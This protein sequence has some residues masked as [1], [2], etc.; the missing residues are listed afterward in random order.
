MKYL[1]S[2][3]FPLPYPVLIVWHG[4][5]GTILFSLLVLLFNWP[6]VL[7][8]GVL[9]FIGGVVAGFVLFLLVRHKL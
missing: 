6:I 7:Q 2:F 8:E 3:L 5:L 1:L 9:A 4:I